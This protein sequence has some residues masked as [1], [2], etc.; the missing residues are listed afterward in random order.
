MVESAVNNKSFCNDVIRTINFMDENGYRLFD[1]TDINRP[2]NV[3]L[4]WLV[5]LVFIKKGGFIDRAVFTLYN[6]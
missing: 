6:Q 5:E 2:W 4:L 3:R 1:I